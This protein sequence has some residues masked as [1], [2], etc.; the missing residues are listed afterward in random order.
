MFDVSSSSNVSS[1]NSNNSSSKN[2]TK[3]PEPV[4]DP[5]PV[6]VQLLKSAYLLTRM[7]TED[8]IDKTYMENINIDEEVFIT[9]VPYFGF[10]S[11]FRPESVKEY[12]EE[13]PMTSLK[14][15]YFCKAVDKYTP[16]E[17]I[18][19]SKD[20]VEYNRQFE[21]TEGDAKIRMFQKESA[22]LA[23]KYASKPVDFKDLDSVKFY[24]TQY[25]L[26]FLYVVSQD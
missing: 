6:A 26:K 18:K 17:S 22:L 23:P 20:T 1:S 14:V 15:K 10:I 19:N 12:L 3:K 13:K 25:I 2:S 4:L 16:N 24:F 11:L 9:E 8:E 21:N 7:V 5:L